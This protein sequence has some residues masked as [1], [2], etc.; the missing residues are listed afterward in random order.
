MF[1]ASPSGNSKPL[2]RLRQVFL[3]VAS[4]INDHMPL[5]LH[6]TVGPFG[7]VANSTFCK[8]PPH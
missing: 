8:R 7:L 1:M 4:G 3:A 6:T 5:V 2:I